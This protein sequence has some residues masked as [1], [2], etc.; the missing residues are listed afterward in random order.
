MQKYFQDLT[1]KVYTG[2]CDHN[3]LAFTLQ[4]L[5]S[6]FSGK[7]LVSARQGR[8]LFGLLRGYEPKHFGIRNT[9]FDIEYADERDLF[10]VNAYASERGA[11]FRNVRFPTCVGNQSDIQPLPKEEF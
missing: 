6:D 3:D 11:A 7:A 8:D 1:N 10:R 5:M 2:N 4:K 9:Q